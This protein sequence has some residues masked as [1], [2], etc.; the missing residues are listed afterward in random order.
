MKNVEWISDGVTLP[1]KIEDAFRSDTLVFFCGAG[2]SIPEPS[3]LPGFRGLTAEIARQL[4]RSDLVPEDVKSDL[5]SEDIKFDV[6]MGQLNEL[7]KDVHRRV[8]SFLSETKDP[9]SYHLNIWRI[10]TA[11][12]KTPR[13]VTTNFDKLFEAALGKLN[14]IDPVPPFHTAPTLPL[15]SDFSGL[16]H[17]HG[18]V[19]LLPTTRM[20]L[21]DRDFG[22]AYITE[23][24]ATQF[25]TRMFEK[26]TVVLVGYSAEDTI[27]QYLNRALPNKGER[28]AFTKA[29]DNPKRWSQLGITPILYPS[30]PEDEY[31][32]LESFM[33]SWSD[34]LTATPSERRDQI[35]SF[36][37]NGPEEAESK[38]D[39]TAWRL[40]D[41]ELARHFRSQ[42]EPATWLKMLDQIEF[43][44]SLFEPDG[45]ENP[46]LKEWAKWACSSMDQD[47]GEGLLSVFARHSG[48]LHH[49]LWLSLW[50][51][52]M[53]GSNKFRHLRQLVF[54]LANSHQ[55]REV[56]NLSRLL[57]RIVKFDSELAEFLLHH[58]LVPYPQIRLVPYP[59]IRTESGRNFCP[60]SLEFQ[61]KLN[62]E[63][64]A[65]SSAWKELKLRLIDKQHLLSLVLNLIHRAEKTVA[66]FSGRSYVNSISRGR[67]QVEKSGRRGDSDQLVVDIARDLL[68]ESVRDHGIREAV[69]Y[70]DDS[71]EMVRRLSIDALAQANLTEADSLITLAI[72]DSLSFDR[73]ARP[74]VFRF[75]KAFYRYCSESTKYSF[76]DH[77][78]NH[79]SVGSTGQERKKLALDCYN[80]VEWL[81]R[82]LNEDDPIKALRDEY[83]LTYNFEPVE[84]PDLPFTFSGQSSPGSSAQVKG[85]FRELSVAEVVEKIHSEMDLEYE[86]PGGNAFRE[87]GDYLKYNPDIHFLLLDEL[88]EK[89]VW[90]VSVWVRVLD[91]IVK[92]QTWLADDVLQRLQ[93]NDSN[94]FKIA[95]RLGSTV[96]RPEERYI[97]SLSNS[98]ERARLLL[99]LWHTA[100][101]EKGGIPH[102]SVLDAQR[103]DRG[104]LALYYTE[105][106]LLIAEQ[107]GEGVLVSP[108]GAAGL[109]QLLDA[110]TCN[111]TDPSSTVLARYSSRLQYRSPVWFEQQLLPKLRNLGVADLSATLW[112][113]LLDGEP[114]DSRL[115]AA[116][117]E[118]IRT[119]LLY[120][121]IAS[122]DSFITLH[123][124]CFASG[125]FSTE[126]NWADAFLVQA[127]ELQKEKWI[128]SVA[129]ILEYGEESQDYETFLIAHWEHRVKQLK[130]ISGIEQR[131][132]LRWLKLPGLERQKATN[133]Y[134]CGPE[135]TLLEEDSYDC[136][137][138]KSP[139]WE[140]HP[141]CFLKATKHLLKSYTS[142]PP[143]LEEVK[144][145]IS[146]IQMPEGALVNDVREELVRLGCSPLPDLENKIG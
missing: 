43:L 80:V 38:R 5:V 57:P 107:Q 83:Q 142:E 31:G 68:R 110:Q 44:D 46:E 90:F 82:D 50:S 54:V 37:E 119:G 22:K 114:I 41:S 8:S 102:V 73:S 89:Q 62:W 14:D 64:S 20:V 144:A 116:L 4:G 26:Y 140:E 49:S 19:D 105:T 42:A 23:G 91:D 93:R 137:D 84:R 118:Q 48:H 76:L 55:P 34:R 81:S 109:Q 11:G 9:N 35:V 104:E 13:I 71:S 56:K 45:E 98:E 99:G 123:A 103:T 60:D 96:A 143:F 78:K 52:I 124:V 32:S 30:P 94:G 145:V 77:I 126:N 51:K 112:A 2:V 125:L 130:N 138:L 15:G 67:D 139:L 29:T 106:L 7:G 61:L 97:D 63:V 85:I 69:S 131:A 36:I 117:K 127:S 28:F 115:R 128:R 53:S 87:L 17:L 79:V 120:V 146:N 121:P 134:I 72:S 122:I 132:F 108:E 95:A 65:V 75:L 12:G 24:W 27:I 133:L 74:E 6:V 21:T 101:Q 100:T 25:L 86:Y 10:A 66:Y 40:N 59:Q 18:E 92:G 135:A 16:V 113:G 111:P 141:E 1:Q 33:R 70:L 3:N 58:L 88:I 47:G 129:D 136:D 39:E